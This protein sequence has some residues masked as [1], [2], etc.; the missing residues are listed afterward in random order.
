VAREGCGL[1]H[2]PGDCAGEWQE[3]GVGWCIYLGTVQRSSNVEVGERKKKE[4]KLQ[5]S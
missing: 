2:L 3:R 1:V 4:V 5:F